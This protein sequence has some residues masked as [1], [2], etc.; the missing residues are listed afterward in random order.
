MRTRSDVVRHLSNIE[1]K[2]ARYK[3][4]V[5]EISISSNLII[6]QGDNFRTDLNIDNKEFYVSV[7]NSDH[8]IINQ[9]LYFITKFMEEQA[10]QIILKQIEVLNDRGYYIKKE[11]IQL[12]NIIKAEGHQI[13]GQT[14][15]DFDFDVLSAD[16]NKYV[17]YMEIQSLD[18][19]DCDNNSSF[20]NKVSQIFE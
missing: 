10:K 2:I 5:D 12:E 16:R 1:S 6:Y 8:R 11:L 4:M 9:S 7:R 19:D 17:P 14:S 18:D 3:V 15:A 20:F 13:L